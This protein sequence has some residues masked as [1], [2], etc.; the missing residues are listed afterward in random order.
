MS[1]SRHNTFNAWWDT[2]VQA[3]ADETRAFRQL[4]RVF[5]VFSEPSLGPGVTQVVENH[6]KNVVA[7]KR[8]FAGCH[9]L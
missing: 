4:S 8:S 2:V 9:L 3:R 7:G 6:G 1:S 5:S